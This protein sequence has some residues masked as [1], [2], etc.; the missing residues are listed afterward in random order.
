LVSNCL[1]WWS[2]IMVCPFQC[3][4]GPAPLRYG[5]PGACSLPDRPRRKGAGRSGQVNV[6]RF[7]ARGDGMDSRCL[8]RAQVPCEPKADASEGVHGL[9]LCKERPRAS[10]VKP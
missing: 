5:L 3:R 9:P 1:M 7:D 6:R 4:I 2:A 10:L 8:N